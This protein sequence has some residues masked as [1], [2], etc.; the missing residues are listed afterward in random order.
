MHTSTIF[1]AGCFLILSGLTGFAGYLVWQ[2][3]TSEGSG[4]SVQGTEIGLGLPGAAPENRRQEFKADSALLYDSHNGTI[5]FEQNGFERR[6]IASITKLMTAMVAL[7]EGIDWEQEVTIKPEEYVQGGTLRL[8][9]G[10]SARMRDLWAASLLGSANNATLAYVRSLGV[11]EEEFVRRMNRK[12]IEMG[13]EQT[14]F[15]DVTGLDPGNVSTAYEVA[16]L[17]AEAFDRYEKIAE[18][19]A[20]T[21]YSMTALG[22][23]RE[24][25]IRNTNKLLKDDWSVTG[26]K[27]GFLYEA[28]Y[29]LVVQGAGAVNDRVAVILGSESG[30]GHFLETRRLLHYE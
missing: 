14:T 13:L 19:T 11:P 9:P 23:G 8:H 21:E 1:W 27:T 28:G 20:M 7:E 24:H 2:A 22:S 29:C 12:A 4:G 17:T 3:H 30:P 10:E 15:V 16:R 18:Y 6:P 26:S 5:V 25:V